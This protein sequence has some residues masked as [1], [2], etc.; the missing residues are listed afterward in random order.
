MSQNN[1]IFYAI[2]AVGINGSGASSTGDIVGA[3]WVKGVQ[4]VGVSTTF[5]LE[6]VFEMGQL[7]V[8]A[9]V[10]NV[11]DVEITLNKVLDG[12][13]LLYQTAATKGKASSNIVAAGDNASSVFLVIYP[14]TNSNASGV[15]NIV[16]HCS[17]MYIGS[18]GYTFPVDGNATEDLTLVG[19]SKSFYNG[20][21]FGSLNT[22]FAPISADPHQPNNGMTRRQNFIMASSI[23]PIEVKNASRGNATGALQSVSISA[24]FGRDNLYELGAYRPYYKFASYPI[25][26]TTDFELISTTGDQVGISTGNNPIN[27]DGAIKVV[28]RAGTGTVYTF[29][30]GAK[31]KLQSVNYSGA[32]TGGGNATVT[33]SYQG[34]NK[35]LIS[36][37]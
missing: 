36:S 15:S 30:L 16:M 19:N 11:A 28:A 24:D 31:N 32:D 7:D 33:L 5:N 34:F 4:S 35:L 12:Y 6:Q 37:D 21:Q 9:N 8:Y 25:T 1:R 27:P 29:D 23:V 10:E 20:S 2:Q 14:D 3:T 26:V 17:G 22:G 18:V 13:D